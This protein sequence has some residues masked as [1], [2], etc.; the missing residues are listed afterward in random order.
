MVK[1]L[2]LP[3]HDGLA[4]APL[5]VLRLEQ[6]RLIRLREHWQPKRVLTVKCS[7][8]VLR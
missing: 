6:I 7:Y 8:R 5:S 1:A 4:Q 2:H 3:L